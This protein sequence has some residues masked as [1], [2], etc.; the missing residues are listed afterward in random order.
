MIGIEQALAKLSIVDLTAA[1]IGLFSLLIFIFAWVKRGETA[2]WEKEKKR[3]DARL[4]NLSP[5]QEV[6][7]NRQQIE[8][9]EEKI[10]S[11]KEVL[12]MLEDDLGVLKPAVEMS[13]SGLYPPAFDY[14]DTEDLKESIRSKRMEQLTLIKS[15]A[16]ITKHGTFTL[17]G[18]LEDG[19]AL[20]DDYKKVFLRT[21]NAE[22]EDI[23]KKL[24]N[25]N[26]DSSSNKLFTIAEQLER[27]GE[28]LSIEVSREYLNLKSSEL[29]I[30]I[31]ELENRQIQKEERKEQQELLREQKKEFAKD[32]E[33]L[34]AQIEFSTAMLN[35]AKKRALELVG[36]TEEDVA[37][38]L[39]SLEKEIAEHEARIEQ[40]MSEAQK[41]KAGYIYVISNIGSFGK[42]VLKIGMTRRLEPMDRVVE[43]GDASVP[44]RFD[45]HTI[46]FVENAPEI[47]RTLHQKF[48]DYRINKENHRKEFFRI[49]VEDV[50]QAMEALDVDSDWYYDVE[51][52]DYSE[53]KLMRAAR[54]ADKEQPSE[55]IYPEAI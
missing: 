28:V 37:D 12:R 52:R 17:F 26:L 39:A 44:Y 30:W 7:K 50:R 19:A 16:A 42:G 48:A 43:L 31:T 46:A 9:V 21:F 14:L 5:E 45:V 18:S 54:L 41:T 24:R 40:S 53:S 22:F 35:K 6:E 36:M 49:S 3:L 27:L 8:E 23:R 25:S 32:E 55:T 38:E 13:R 1:V 2:K 4:L 11:G 47:E 34:E 15:G 10:A 51:A 33:D 29:D 20:V